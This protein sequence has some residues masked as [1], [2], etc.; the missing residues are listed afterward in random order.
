MAPM[1]IERLTLGSISLA[2]NAA[3]AQDEG[4]A[5]VLDAGH[6]LGHLAAAQ[7]MDMAIAKARRFGVGVVAV[8]R[9]FHFG[10]AGR[11]AAQAARAGC[12]GVAMC[13][14]R[15]MMAPPGGLE[16]VVG[17]NPLAIAAPTQSGAPIL[18]D[19]AMSEVALARVRGGAPWGD[20][21]RQLGGRP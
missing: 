19:M 15:P 18:L 12:I 10:V 2:Q 20:D 9:G 1:Y 16:P 11:Y 6:M 7:A 13:N 4:A 5:M 3:V 17:N 14:T 21:S 8:R